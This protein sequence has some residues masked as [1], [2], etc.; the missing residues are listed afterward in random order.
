MSNEEATEQQRT[1]RDL[2]EGIDQF[3]MLVDGVPDYAL[4]LINPQGQVATW[5]SGAQRIKGYTAEEIIGKP[6]STF[7][8]PEDIAT[9]MPNEILERARKEG[10]A[11]HEGWRVRK[12]GSKLWV[13]AVVT[14]LHDKSGKL[15]GFSKITRDVTEK[16]KQQTALHREIREKEEAQQRLGKSE[17]S[18]RAF[19]IRLLRTQDEERRRIGREMHDS[20]GQYLS[21]LKIK[22]GSA[23]CEVPKSRLRNWSGIVKLLQHI[24]RVRERGSNDFVLAL[25]AHARRNGLEVCYLLVPRRIYATKRH[26]SPVQ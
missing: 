20:L 25:P 16:M 12:D 17:E 14:A 13:H 18:L 26:R 4:Y 9:G 7:F 21:G 11:E 5:N 22:T 1:L 15:V 10:R 8:L 6:F 2:G 23:G 24:G 3:R 19:S